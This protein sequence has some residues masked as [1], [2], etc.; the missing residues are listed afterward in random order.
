MIRYWFLGYCCQCQKRL[1]EI[2]TTVP[3]SL[4]ASY[5]VGHPVH[6]CRINYEK[7]SFNIIWKTLWFHL[8]VYSLKKT[9]RLIRANYILFPVCIRIF[10]SISEYSC[11]NQN[12]PVL[13]RIFLSVSEY[14]CL[15][16]NIPVLTRIFLS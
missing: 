8:V 11:L 1:L 12:I 14:S 15:N 2:T 6:K 10:L 9:T 13:I 7:R 5:S 3:V 16:Q 4:F